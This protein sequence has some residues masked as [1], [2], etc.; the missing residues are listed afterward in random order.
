M[1]YEKGYPE[2][3]EDIWD[4]EVEGDEILTSFGYVNLN[5]NLAD[6]AVEAD[7]GC[8]IDHSYYRDD[9]DYSLNSLAESFWANTG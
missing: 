2:Y 6:G 3:L 4:E 8:R 5:S 9:E 1:T 7:V